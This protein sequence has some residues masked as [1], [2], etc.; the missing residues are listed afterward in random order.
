MSLDKE[1][2][3]L[4]SLH[5]MKNCARNIGRYIIE[6][7][8]HQWRGATV[9]HYLGTAS[10]LFLKLELL[11]RTGTFKARAAINNVLLLSDEQRRRGITTVSAG[12]HAIATAYAG[13]CF[14]VRAKVVMLAS[15]NPARVEAVRAYGAELVLAEDGV[16]GFEMVEKIIEQEGMC[17]V[18]AFEGHSVTVATATCGLELM[19]SVKQL[20]AVIVPIGGGGLCSGIA[21]AVKSITPDCKVYGVEP[22]GAAVM[23]AS[24]RAGAPQRL[25]EQSTIADSL[26]PPMT[27]PYAYAMCRRF[28]DEIVLVEDDQI[29]AAAALLFRELKLAVEPAA[30]VSTAAAFGPLRESLQN[31]RTG[32][33][34]CGAN[35]DIDGFSRL[36][37][38]GNNALAQKALA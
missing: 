21:A 27:L 5:D 12:N 14:G 37:E 7:P 32:L 17:L 33:I 22:V 3:I 13:A 4:P 25:E 1:D 9:E 26:T 31:R 20:D 19:A 2:F 38:R 15:A 8:T 36:V 10:E 11:Q 16:K 23:D 30:A 24:F 35:I 28:V 29:A 18:P 6:T 34:I